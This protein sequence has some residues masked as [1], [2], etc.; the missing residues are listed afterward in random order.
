VVSDTSTALLGFPATKQPPRST[1]SCSLALHPHSEQQ[2]TI[3]S[4]QFTE[5]VAALVIDNGYVFYLQ[6][7]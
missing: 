4:F 2:L 6:H 3:A 5:E 7:H 1:P